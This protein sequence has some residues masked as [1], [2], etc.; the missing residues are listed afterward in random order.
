MSGSRIY[1]HAADVKKGMVLLATKYLGTTMCTSYFAP[2]RE[3]VKIQTLPTILSGFAR[4]TFYILKINKPS[5]ECTK[6]YKLTYITL[7]YDI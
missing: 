3:Q 5:Y 1:N 7:T 4:S 6:I 2:R